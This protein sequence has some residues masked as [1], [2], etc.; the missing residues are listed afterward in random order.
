MQKADRAD[1]AEADLAIT[2]TVAQCC[3]DN[4]ESMV[5]HM[6]VWL[7]SEAPKKF[8][9]SSSLTKVCICIIILFR[10]SHIIINIIIIKDTFAFD[11]VVLHNETFLSEAHKKFILARLF[12]FILPYNTVLICHDNNNHLFVR[13]IASSFLLFF[14]SFSR[15]VSVFCDNFVFAL[16]INLQVELISEAPKKF[17]FS[18][19]LIIS[20]ILIIIFTIKNYINNNNKNGKDKIALENAN[21]HNS[22]NITEA[23]KK[24]IL[25]RLVFFVVFVFIFLFLFCHFVLNN[26]FF[27]VFASALRKCFITFI[28]IFYFSATATYINNHAL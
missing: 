10:I 11:H 15:S 22:K 8:I 7:S 14:S 3:Y 17:I 6:Q 1:R 2:D 12:C 16:I 13:F 25:A 27:D 20:C 19:L 21:K 18:S 23:H 4:V 26:I 24:I 5:L 28:F 9:F